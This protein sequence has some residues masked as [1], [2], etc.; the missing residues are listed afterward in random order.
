MALIHRLGR[1]QKRIDTLR[2][3]H[4]FPDNG[5]EHADAAFLTIYEALEDLLI[6]LDAGQDELNENW[7]C[8][9]AHIVSAPP[10]TNLG[11]SAAKIVRAWAFGPA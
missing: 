5:V 8:R 7:V 6:G 1:L 9:T 4:K 2:D 11:Y 10:A 3:V